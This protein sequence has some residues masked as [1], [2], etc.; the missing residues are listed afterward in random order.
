MTAFSFESDAID[1]P[2]GAWAKTHRRTLRWRGRDVLALTQGLRRAYVYPLYTPA[3]FA[4]TTE[5]PADHPHHNSLWIASDHLHCLVPA[6]GKIEEYTYNFY[7]DETFQGRAPGRVRETGVAAEEGQDGSF[8]IEQA[9][10]WVGPVEWAADGGR[11][12]MTERRTLEVRPGE[13]HHLIDIRSALTPTEW[14]VAL[15]PT[16]H[17]FFNF[18]VAESMRGARGG[19][20]RDAEGR[21]GGAAITAGAARW[22]H[23]A[24]PVGGGA[25]AGIAIGPTAGIEAPSWFAADW[26]T[27]TLQPYRH[28]ARKIVRGETLAMA[29]RVVVHDGA[30]EPGAVDALFG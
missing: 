22:V 13:H 5:S 21:V 20:L 2:T 7:V 28:H 9:L 25:V 4:V 14:D 18:R 30:M 26:G 19:R 29:V 23:C 15:G 11:T 10:D 24:G 16:R 3:G 6:D 1:L 27:V 12:V 17:A 8:R